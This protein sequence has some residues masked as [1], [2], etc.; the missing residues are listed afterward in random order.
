MVITAVGCSKATNEAEKDDEI[1][2]SEESD[3][4]SEE[5]KVIRIGTPGQHYPWN[6]FEAGHLQGAD[7]ETIEEIARRI[8]YEAKFDI[9]AFEGLYGSVDTN[10]IDTGA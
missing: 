4:S 1:A 3:N 2:S 6:F 7:I 9:M 8:G 10:R 5:K